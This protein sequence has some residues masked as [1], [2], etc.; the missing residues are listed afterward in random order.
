MDL[1]EKHIF[2][3]TYSQ[4]SHVYIIIRS[5]SLFLINLKLCKCG[6]NYG[7]NISFHSSFLAYYVGVLHAM[8]P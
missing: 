4:N 6:N 1:L 5:Q 2:F 7:H 8:I 3:C